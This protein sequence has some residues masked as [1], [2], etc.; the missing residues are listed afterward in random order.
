MNTEETID[1]L[2]SLPTVYALWW[3]I[4]NITDEDPRRSEIF[5]HLRERVREF[6]TDFKAAHRMDLAML[7]LKDAE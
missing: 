7:K 6:Q 2:I 1:Y 5:F 3:F 4:E